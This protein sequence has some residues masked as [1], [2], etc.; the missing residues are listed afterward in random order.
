MS[1]LIGKTS[2]KDVMATCMVHLTAVLN[3]ILVYHIDQIHGNEVHLLS[4]KTRTLL[5][6]YF[7]S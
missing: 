6:V 4:L 3:V 1:I 5:T 2:S 7:Y